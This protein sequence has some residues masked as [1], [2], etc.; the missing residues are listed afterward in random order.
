MPITF[1][2]VVRIDMTIK[3][4]I[5]GKAL[6]VGATGGMGRAVARVLAQQGL[7]LALLGRNVTAT[8]QIVA[9]CEGLG[10]TAHAVVCDIAKIDTIE[11]A[12]AGAIEKMAGLNYLINC[13]GISPEGK[14]HDSD[15]LSAEAILDTNLRAH[16]Y[17][18]RY[19]LPEIN[20]N[21]GGAVVRIGAVNWVYSGVN[22]YTAANRGA[23]GLAEAMFEDVRE[24]G[25]RVCTIKPGWVNTPLVT[26]TN[27]D[28]DLM[29]Q[30]ED[31]AQAVLFVLAMPVSACVTEM[32]ILPQRS[33]YIS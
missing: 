4:A 5:E 29:I 33:P 21:S 25:T 19:A 24:F 11:A 9:Q 6:V 23:E 31:V 20:R 18:A 2:C 3:T 12:V 26:E 28:K 15:L 30:P 1:V 22:T 13:A 7:E 27:I 8:A 10:A 14:L 17:L 32:T 16:L